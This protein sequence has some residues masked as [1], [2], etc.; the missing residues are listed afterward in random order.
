MF[1][2]IIAVDSYANGTTGSVLIRIKQGAGL[3]SS[4]Y[5]PDS[6]AV[7]NTGAK[8]IASVY[9]DL[10]TSIFP[11]MVFD[12]IGLAGD[13]ASRGLVVGS[14]GNTGVLA[15]V[16]ASSLTPFRGL[17]GTAGYKGMQVDFSPTTLGGFQTNE[18][19]TFG[20]DVDPASIRGINPTVVTSA[21]ATLANWD[22]GGVSGAELIGSTVTVRFTDGTTA[23]GRLASDGSQ[24]G[25]AVKLV[26]GAPATTTLSLSVNG[27]AA[28]G[29]GF[30]DLEGNQVLVQGT[31]GQVARITMITGFTQPFDFTASNG[32]AFDISTRLAADAFGANNALEVQTV[33]VTLTGGVQNVTGL[34]DFA[35]PGGA[36]RFA[37][38]NALPVAFTASVVDAAGVS[39]GPLV[40]PIHLDRAAVP[41]VVVPAEVA[42]ISRLADFTQ[43]ALK[44]V[45]LDNPTTINVGADGKLYVTQQNGLIVVLTVA[46]T[47]QLLSGVSTETWQVTGRQ[48]I[49]L[50]QKMPNHDDQGNFQASVLNRQ[51]TGAVTTLDAHGRVMLYVT[52]SDPRIGGGTAATDLNLD[53]NS[54][55]ISRLVQKTDAAGNLVLNAGKP[56]WEK[57][58]LVRGFARSEENH[59]LNGLEVATNAAGQHVLIVTSGGSTNAG[60]QSAFFG[61]T[62]EYYTSTAIFEVNLDLLAAK[63]ASQGLK[64]YNPGGNNPQSYLHDMPT[65][66][67]P[68]RANGS[69]GLDLAAGNKPGTDIFGGNDGLN[70]AIFD[71][72]GIVRLIASGFRNQYDVV[73]AQNGSLYTID[74]GANAG[75]GG[76]PVNAAGSPIVDANA[77][78]V[79]DN[80]PVSNRPGSG[81]AEAPDSLHRVVLD[82]TQPIGQVYYAGHPNPTRASGASAGLYLYAAA[83]NAF[84]VAAGTPLGIVAGKLAPVAAPVDLAPLVS[85]INK[86]LP[87]NAAGASITDPREGL[88]LKPARADG[89][90][91]GPDKALWTFFNST[92]GLD[93]YT[94]SNGMKSDLLAVS[95]DGRIYAIELGP[96]GTV[97]SVESRLLTTT[98]LDVTAQGDRDPYPGVI[99]VAAYGSDQ[100]VILSPNRGVGVTPNPSDRDQDGVGD[101][102]DP[103][104]ADPNNGTSQVL[105]GGEAWVWTFANDPAFPAP[106]RSA[107]LFD[108]TGGLFAGGG[109]G[110]TGI[111]TNRAGLPETLFSQSNI[112][113][114]G[115]PGI[116]QLIGTEPGSPGPDTQ[117]NGFQLGFTPSASLSGFL[118]QTRIDNF[119]DEKGQVGAT[120]KLVQGLFVGAGDQDNFLSVA[121]VRLGNGKTGFEVQWQF[122]ASFVGETALASAFYEVA[123]LGSVNGTDLVTLGLD[124]SRNGSVIPLWSYTIGGVQHGGAGA[125]VQLGGDALAALQGR[126]FLPD[127]TG[128]LKPVGFAVGL[129]GSRDGTTGRLPMDFED[130]SITA[131][132]GLDR[133]TLVKAVNAGGPAFTARDGTVF[134]AD[135]LNSGSTYQ[136]NTAIAGTDDDALYQ[137]ERSGAGGFTYSV[138]VANG[139]YIVDLYFAEIWSGNFAA[140]RRVFDVRLEGQTVLDDLD[141]FSRA[142]ANRAVVTEHLVTVTDGSLT[143]TTAPGLENPTLSAFAVWNQASVSGTPP[144]ARI[145]FG[146]TPLAP[147]DKL[148][149]TVTLTDDQGLNASTIAASDTVFASSAGAVSVQG[150]TIALAADGKS[151]SITYQ[152]GVAN[153]WAEGSTLTATVAG[154]AVRD[155]G[156]SGNA[157]TSAQ[158]LHDDRFVLAVNSGGGAYTDSRGIVYRADTV[159][160]GGNYTSTAAITGTVDDSLY[161]SRKSQVGGSVTYDVPI[162]NGSFDV[163]LQFAETFDAAA[164][165]GRRIFDVLLEGRLAI[166]NLDIGAL[167]GP[168]AAL[169]LVRSTTVADGKLTLTLVPVVGNAT[170]SAFSVWDVAP[171]G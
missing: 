149:A 150:S 155:T 71:P 23:Q 79:P 145:A 99:F 136:V 159:P 18:T 81:P 153:G 122:A 60:A 160:N 2:G 86:L 21:G 170:I 167:A 82:Y 93:E 4:T 125:A 156:G 27:T 161:Q 165:P 6:I 72:S 169:D 34:F 107:E 1:E 146:P 162:R 28:G 133:G 74:N 50:V 11:D 158:Y 22:S 154:N 113:F 94:A 48:D 103:F 9:F 41:P 33:N 78:G 115:A 137:N 88:Y 157:A 44:G 55:V 63:Q 132:G 129:L 29:E 47:V 24:G 142:G 16:S 77:N 121:L 25:S 20:V 117:R 123:G 46:R 111:L 56:V 45:T 32:Q 40:E 140:G 116:L 76:T 62:S 105:R 127:A 13:T 58:D 54:G 31:A 19:V 166:D 85:N 95:F 49:D 43:L 110:F 83:G 164:L 148:T 36:L 52:S 12:P 120:E 14:S 61:F 26:Q 65:L 100:I 42:A 66:D 67:D 163:I 118:V 57:V 139:T 141:L 30:Y 10:T 53:T 5:L 147:R 138:P 135:T 51:V 3:Q 128:G 108:G 87:T 144:Q 124:V 17:G 134:A 68:T 152:L 101:T 109:I 96:D 84:G 89:I 143:L 75:W 114:G 171:L 130:L 131:R 37:G 80:G 64:V 104:S 70:Q 7:T 92:N 126:F 102:I 8:R 69:D 98:P 112:I 90:T 151:A 106:N 168:N 91:N 39:T 59:S 97:A 73:L 35:P 15:P 119:L 38:D